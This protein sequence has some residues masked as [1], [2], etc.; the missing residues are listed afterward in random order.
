MDAKLVT[1][2]FFP[3]RIQDESSPAKV[4]K[5][6]CTVSI[7]LK[8]PDCSLMIWLP[9]LTDGQNTRPESEHPIN[10]IYQHF[11]TEICPN[12]AWRMV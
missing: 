2:S 7:I 8:S 3:C 9:L 11:K 6:S 1:C 12:D 5:N 10:L 4:I